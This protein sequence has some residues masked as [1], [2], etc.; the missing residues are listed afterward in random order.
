VV[1]ISG[2]D[3]PDVRVKAKSAG[4]TDFISKSIG[5]VELL[6]RLEAL[7]QLARTQRDL[8]ESRAALATASPVDPARASPRRPIC[9]TTP[10]RS[11]PWPS[12]T[13]ASCR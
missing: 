9:T 2:D 11:C 4:A 10:A 13:R 7:T 1:V 12:A 6:A 3:E 5:N 8:E